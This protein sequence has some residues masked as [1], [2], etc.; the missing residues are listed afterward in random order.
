M[1]GTKASMS[2]SHRQG[3]RVSWT[4]QAGKATGANCLS[5]GS[6]AAAREAQKLQVALSFYGW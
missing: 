6:C 4:G 3:R 5:T 1:G 2:G